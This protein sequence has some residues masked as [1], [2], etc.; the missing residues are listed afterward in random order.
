MD[1]TAIMSKRHPALSE[2]RVAL[3]HQKHREKSIQ[4]RSEFIVGRDLVTITLSDDPGDELQRPGTRRVV[5]GRAAYSFD[6]EVFIKRI[7]NGAYGS[8]CKLMSAAAVPDDGRMVPILDVFKLIICDAHCLEEGESLQDAYEAA[9]REEELQTPTARAREI[10]RNEDKR[11]RGGTPNSSSPTSSVYHPKSWR[12]WRRTKV[13]PSRQSGNRLLPRLPLGSR[14]LS[15]RNNPGASSSTKAEWPSRDLATIGKT[16]GAKSNSVQ[17][18]CQWL[19]MEN[20]TMST[21]C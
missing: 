21:H 2:E 18:G 5:L 19:S 9:L 8:C 15:M 3:L 20:A 6:E 12:R 7:S 17:A 14:R 16:C 10:V 11:R 13:A 4:R 1:S